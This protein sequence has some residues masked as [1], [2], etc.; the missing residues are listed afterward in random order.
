MSDVQRT[1]ND[2]GEGSSSI[3]Q[4]ANPLSSEGV[5][6]VAMS[7]Y[8]I[9]RYPGLWQAT[10]LMLAVNVLAGVLLVPWALW[11]AMRHGEFSFHPAAMAACNVGAFGLVCWYGRRKAGLN[12]GEVFPWKAVQW[13]LLAG[14]AAAT[15]GVDILLSDVDNV[16][17]RFV[18]MPPE[19]V[20]FFKQVT[21]GASGLGWSLLLVAV[22]APF[23]EEFLFRG[24]IQGGLAARYGERGGIAWTALLFG[25]M[26]L[27]PWQMVSAAI[28][29]VLAGWLMAR[30]GSLIPCVWAHMVGN[31]AVTLLPRVPYEIRGF[32][33]PVTEVPVMQPLWF[34]AVGLALLAAGIAWIAAVTARRPDGSLG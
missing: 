16:L 11:T 23:T 32:N 22:V 4:G 18:P 2:G 21:G 5:A 13:A 7:R 34:D 26:H 6:D 10:W 24:L 27:N 9:T 25:A 8:G 14:V 19:M 33:T 12:W 20:E 28:F 30:T 17:R 31:A 29:G 3:S 15:V 1:L